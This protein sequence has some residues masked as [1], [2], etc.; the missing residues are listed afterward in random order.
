MENENPG[1]IS[2]LSIGTNDFERTV[3]FYDKVL[4]SSGCKPPL[5]EN[6]QR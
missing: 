6:R 2:H 1:I 3:A 4:P 5:M